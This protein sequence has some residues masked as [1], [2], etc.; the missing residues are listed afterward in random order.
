MNTPKI[1]FNK[2]MLPAAI[3]STLVVAGCAKDE[4]NADLRVIHASPDAPSV[5]VQISSRTYNKEISNLDYAASSGYESVR[6]GRRDVT[7]EAII[8]GGNLDVLSEPGFKF[9]MGQ[10]YNVLAVG[11]V[12]EDPSVD[13][14][15][16]DLLLV[17][18]SAANP[19]A[20]EVAVAVV[21][22]SADAP[23]VDVYV[24]APGTDVSDPN[25]FP[26]FTFDFKDPA[27]DAGSLPAGK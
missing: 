26:N 11:K 27:V 20:G 4:K 7:V 12:A 5:N 10:R 9:D 1:L 15:E 17:E 25:L 24:T 14:D 8:P 21:H 18:E 6:S 3:A 23:E 22:A 2:V 19:G 16:L 13:G